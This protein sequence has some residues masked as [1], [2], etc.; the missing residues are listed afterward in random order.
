MNIAVTTT[1]G[2]APGLNAAI[3]GVVRAASQYGWTVVG[4]RDGFSGL[5]G[6]GRSVRSP[7]QLDPESVRRALHNGGTVLGAANDDDPTEL[8]G[9]VT[10][11]ARALDDSGIEGLVVVGGDGS[12]KVAAAL[13]AEGVSVVGVPKTI[14]RDLVG[15]EATIGFDTAVEFAAEAVSRL[16]DTADAH[17]R[18]HVVEVMGRDAG[19]LALHAALAGDADA[20]LLPELAPDLTIVAD[21]LRQ[22]VDRQGH[23]VVVVAEGVSAGE[24]GTAAQ[25][26]AQQLGEMLA[27]NVRH[28]ALAHLLRGGRPV[29]SDR[30]HGLRLGS[31][32]VAALAEGSSGVL[33]A[34]DGS[35][36]VHV[37]LSEVTERY[38]TV[39]LDDPTLLAARRTG[40]VLGA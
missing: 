13:S 12:Q 37:P 6:E 35:K 8:S 29:A 22:V 18:L 1:G 25:H 39:P 30:L 16:R 20:V 28:M 40:V 36:V 38:R 23:A 17:H 19:W 21:G 32:A 2:D 10:R 26:V 9:S 5:L 4:L 27:V 24:N 14:D 31:A 34:W 3:V 11:I 33:V 15:S 7:V